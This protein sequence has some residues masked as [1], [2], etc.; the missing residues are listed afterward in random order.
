MDINISE[1]RNRFASVCAVTIL[2]NAAISVLI[3][4]KETEPFTATFPLKL[5][6]ALMLLMMA[7]E[8]ASKAMEHFSDTT[9]ES[10]IYAYTDGVECYR[11]KSLNGIYG[12]RYPYRIF[13][14]AL[15]APAMAPISV[16]STAEIR[17]SESMITEPNI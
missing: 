5:P 7:L 11:R 12:N 8:T 1:S 4:L 16:L 13:L 14:A 9:F 15:T 2:T 3:Q 17:I 6:A 10:L